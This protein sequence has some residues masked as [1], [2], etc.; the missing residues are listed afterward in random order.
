MNE[1]TV[2]SPWF[3][4]EQNESF[5]LGCI[6]KTLIACSQP[7]QYGVALMGRPEIMLKYMSNFIDSP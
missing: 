2:P 6:E 5:M 7:G 4:I 3:T 1:L